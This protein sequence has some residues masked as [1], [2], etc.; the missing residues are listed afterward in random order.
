MRILTDT[1]LGRRAGAHTNINSSRE[2]D[3]AIFNNAKLATD[4][5]D[6]TVHVGD[7]FD[8]S[9]NPE[10]VLLQG[11]HIAG[12]CD[13]ILGGN[14]DLSNRE[15]TK[16]SIEVVGNVHDN[17]CH[18]Q[19]SEVKFEDF[20][21]EDDTL[22]TIVPHHSSQD[23]FDKALDLVCTNTEDGESGK[24]DLVFLHCNFNSPFAQNDSSLNLTPEQAEK[25]LKSFKYI[26]LG[27]E[28]SH[29]W[30]MDERL[31]I[32]GN[33]HPTNFGDIS[34]KFFWDYNPNDGFTKTLCW[35]KDEQ[36][37]KLKAS[38]LVK[39][40]VHMATTPNFIEIVGEDFDPALA[41]DLASAMQD[42]WDVTDSNLYMVRN[43]VNFKQIVATTIDSGV[44]LE[45]VTQAITGDLRETDLL[46]LWQ[47]HLG[48]A[49]NA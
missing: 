41:S 49:Q 36:Y 4:T 21:D 2:L 33:T 6:T 25:L 42:I 17:L 28:H 8:K 45:D 18:A 15:N 3:H 32:L 47:E 29:R 19:V 14:H 20:E 5:S 10:Y 13:V 9:H 35:S 31:L 22:F 43:N 38:D 12:R 26:V 30:E 23:L 11:L 7:L 40:G 39:S 24:R 37:L 44:Q 46:E 16:T 1:H 34:D 48:V 27:H